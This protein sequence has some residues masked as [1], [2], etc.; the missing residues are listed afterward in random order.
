[1]CQWRLGT[2]GMIVRQAL[3][4]LEIQEMAHCQIY[5]EYLINAQGE[6]VVAGVRTGKQVDEMKKDLPDSYKQLV[7][8]CERL[9]KHYKEP[10]DIEF[11]I[12][13]GKFYLLQT[14]KCKNECIRDGKN[15]CRYGKRKIN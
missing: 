5:G 15:I 4:L 10:Q 14:R 9:E 13:Q 1:M 7:K 11:T 3:C 8:T 6:D 12:E 2:W